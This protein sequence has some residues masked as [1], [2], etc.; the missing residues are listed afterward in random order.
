MYGTIFKSCP[1]LIT[2]LV[3]KIWVLMSLKMFFS[4]VVCVVKWTCC[5]L[6]TNWFISY[7]KPT[8]FEW[9]GLFISTSAFDV[10][11]FL[12]DFSI[13]GSHICFFICQSIA[14]FAFVGSCA[15]NTCCSSTWLCV[16]IT[17]TTLI[18]TLSSLEGFYIIM[19]VVIGLVWNIF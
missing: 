2:Y 13:K 7:N 3:S 16:M 10:E 8:Q 12:C 5:L 6:I 9:S 11:L 18:G 17:T 1:K 15:L 4:N 14:N 19:V